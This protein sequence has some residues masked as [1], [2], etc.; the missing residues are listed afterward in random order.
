MTPYSA[1]AAPT[2]AA[3]SGSSLPT[4]H[5]VPAPRAGGREHRHDIDL[6]R[7]ICSCAV[8]LGHVGGAFISAVDRREANGP[9]AYWVGHIADAANQFAVPMFFAMAGWAVLVG[10]PPRD[11]RQVRQRIIRNGLPL[12]VWT[13]CYLAW[14]WLRG[15]NEDPVTDLAVD[16]VFGSV[17]PAYHLWF[18]YAYIPIVMALSF[19]LLVKAGQRPW[20]LGAALLAVA[21]VPTVLTTAREVTGWEAPAVGWGFGTY[22]VVYAL[23]GALLF[24]LPTGVPRRHRWL[25]VPVILAAIAGCL[26]YD[27]QVK[28]VIPNAHLFVAVLSACVLLLVSRVR[29]PERLR[30]ALTKLAGASLGAFMVHVVFVE[31]LVRPLVSADLSGPVAAA[32]LVGL[33]LGT[34]VLSYAA[35]LLWGRLG[36]RRFLG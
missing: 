31:E 1:S 32:L 20:G 8:I 3:S 16:S 2:E 28:Y 21:T 13:G 10:A 5:T 14:A 7:L 23:L 12:V 9:G 22:S 25:L 15:R 35:S 29:I 6:M 24:A 4:V 26:W 34:I 18:M 17:Q 11:G 30:P 19:A 36:L 33:V 27:T